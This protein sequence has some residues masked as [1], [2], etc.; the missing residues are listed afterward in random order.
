MFAQGLDL[1]GQAVL[2]V[3]AV[4]QRQ[5][6]VANLDLEV[7]HLEGGGDGLIHLRFFMGGL[8]LF[9]RFEHSHIILAL[10]HFKRE[11]SSTSG[12]GPERQHRHAGQQPHNHHHCGRHAQRFGVVGKL[13]AQRLGGLP[14]HARLRDQQARCG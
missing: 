14:A 6:R 8:R 5:E 9:H 3:F 1:I 13:S 4:H 7:I 2:S 10:A 11:V 12:K